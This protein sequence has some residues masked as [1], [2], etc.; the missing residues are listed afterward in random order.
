MLLLHLK[1]VYIS[2]KCIGLVH[3]EEG[4]SDHPLAFL[5]SK[6]MEQ[7]FIKFCVWA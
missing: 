4:I 7:I 6:I 5:I 2:R 3:N 1:H